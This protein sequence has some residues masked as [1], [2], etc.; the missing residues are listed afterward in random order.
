MRIDRPEHYYKISLERIRQARILYEEGASFTLSM[1]IAGVAVECM[2]RG[3]KI[4]RDP[5]FDEKHDLRKLFKSSGML[6]LDPGLLQS[7]GLTETQIHEHFRKI[8]AAASEICELW[9]NDYRFASEERIRA[10]LKLMKLDRGVKGNPLKEKTRS[11]L[12]ASQDI[13]D[14][15]VFQWNLLKRS[16]TC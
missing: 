6:R 8:Q 11:L 13:I 12:K 3:F 14:K 16:G 9:S 2:L 10:H 15:G 4:L 7:K 1:Y 5:T